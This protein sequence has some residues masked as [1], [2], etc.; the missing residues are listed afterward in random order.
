MTKQSLQL[1]VS[2]D[3]E[4]DT[5]NVEQ[6]C[7]QSIIPLIESLE[8]DG[9][10][11]IFHFNG[12]LLDYLARRH[13]GTIQ[14]LGRLI[15]EGRAE[16]LG[17]MFYGGDLR[18]ISDLDVRAQIDMSDGF[19]ES[20]LGEAPLGYYSPELRTAAELPRLLAETRVE[21]TFVSRTALPTD[22]RVDSGMAVLSRGGADSVAFVTDA[23]ADGQSPLLM[24][25]F[26]SAVKANPAQ[27]LTTLVVKADRLG[28]LFDE[29]AS[30]DSAD[31]RRAL[32]KWLKDLAASDTFEL[33]LPLSSYGHAQALQ[34]VP[35]QE[36][37]RSGEESPL[38]AMCLA[39]RFIQRVS[40]ELRDAIGLMEDEEK[41]EFW[42]DSLATAQRDI[43]AAQ[44]LS[45]SL[46]LNHSEKSYS[47][48]RA[49]YERALRGAALVD[50]LIADDEDFM[51]LEEADLNGDSRTEYMAGTRFLQVWFDLHQGRIIHLDDRLSKRSWLDEIGG[52][53]DLSFFFSS[54]RSSGDAD[55][56]AQAE[57]FNHFQIEDV[58]VDEEAETFFAQTQAETKSGDVA[59]KLNLDF[60]LPVA[61]GSI[62]VEAVLE[63]SGESSGASLTALGVR[64]PLALS[65][66][67]IMR[68]DG[69]AVGGEAAE[70]NEVQKVII[71]EEDKIL[72]TFSFKNPVKIQVA[73]PVAETRVLLA[74]AKPG[75]Q[76]HLQM[77]ILTSE[78][79]SSEDLSTKE[80]PSQIKES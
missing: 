6:I 14:R 33:V 78:E 38:A 72:L 79:Q 55:P 16:V 70:F 68:V 76:S 11:L 67:M 69:E 75:E 45:R 73:A 9:P 60:S 51:A 37:A 19:W 52:A 13:E 4:L 59:H 30:A 34:N 12:L 44:T 63:S 3:A 29:N 42:S 22:T 23:L 39:C 49:A 28:S 7:E 35:M 18:W 31:G 17:G 58:G 50:S 77:D 53:G 43:F 62:K 24:E 71:E 21:Y 36:F 47:L 32:K 26:V 74:I 66:A 64:I 15:D 65:K 80:V 56:Q 5:P 1:I 57:S 25:T 8:E 61:P 40:A 48:R 10:K 20:I 54:L 2:F 27:S 46:H 41:E